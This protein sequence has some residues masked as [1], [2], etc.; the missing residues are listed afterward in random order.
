LVEADSNFY[1]TTLF[2]GL[3]QRGAV[4]RMTPDGVLTNLI[5]FNGTNGAHPWAGLM[6]GPDCNFYGTTAYGG[7]GYTGS[8]LTG[9][10]TI[11]QMTSE[12][13]LTSL[14]HFSGTNGAAPWSVLTRGNE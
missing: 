11:F 5:F 9:Y 4:F 7:I 3:Y 13:T 10:G 2:G 1:G 12:G 8:L 14:V 6:S